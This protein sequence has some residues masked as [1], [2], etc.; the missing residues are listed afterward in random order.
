MTRKPLEFFN[1]DKPMGYFR[2]R[3]YPTV[4]GRYR[5]SPYR[6]VGHLRLVQGLHKGSTV[7]CWFSRRRQKASLVISREDFVEGQC[8]CC[9]YVVV[10]E[11][12]PA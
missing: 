2:E 3:G 12:G 8:E 9:W 11:M 6:G 10:L 7:E 4:P 5:Y 1:Q